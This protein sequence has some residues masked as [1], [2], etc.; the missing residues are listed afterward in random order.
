M[1]HSHLLWNIVIK[2]VLDCNEFTMIW[3]GMKREKRHDNMHCPLWSWLWCSY[4]W[5]ISHRTGSTQ[6]LLCFCN[7]L[8]PFF[9]LMLWYQVHLVS[10]QYLII[11]FPYISQICHELTKMI[12]FI[13]KF[14][15]ALELTKFIKSFLWTIGTRPL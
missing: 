1:I 13:N 7:S 12:E 14:N 6:L 15:D 8:F 5:L 4:A 11:V 3:I 10:Y 2:D 9:C